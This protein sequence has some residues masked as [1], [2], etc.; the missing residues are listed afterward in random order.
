[1]QRKQQKQNWTLVL[2][3]YEA[4]HGTDDY[5]FVARVVELYSGIALFATFH[6]ESS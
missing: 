4:V 5:S 1:M 6:T 3:I 2:S